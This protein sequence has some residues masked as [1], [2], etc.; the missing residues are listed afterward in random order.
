MINDV[1]Y[2]KGGVIMGL[3]DLFKKTKTKQEASSISTYAMYMPKNKNVKPSSHD[4]NIHPDIINLVWIGDGSYKNYDM[5]SQKLNDNIYLQSG[6]NEPSTLYLD[7]PISKPLDS[8]NVPKPGYYPSYEGL[9][10]EQRWMYWEF[11]SNPYNSD[12]NIGYVFI[13][14]YGLERF[15]MKKNRDDA[16]YMVFKLIDVHSNSSFQS[17]ALA[18]LFYVCIT[19]QKANWAEALI[20]FIS[21]RPTLSIDSELLILLKFRR[22][23]P[24]YA[25]DI[26]RFA[27]RFGYSNLRYINLYPDMFTAELEKFLYDAYGVAQVDLNLFFTDEKLKS[28]EKTT[29]PVC[30]NYTLSPREFKVPNIFSNETF[31]LSMFKI[32][33]KTHESLKVSLAAARKSK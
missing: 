25:T 6:R 29:L 27:R 17:Y 28:M 14:Y 32:L 11:L 24:L 12:I 5:D 13:F 18:M 8:F 15:I 21:S 20:N 33:Q 7:L 1:N 30:A 26:V 3:F 22:N 4:L 16:F 19:K 23:I 9:S 2:N 31:K 10:L